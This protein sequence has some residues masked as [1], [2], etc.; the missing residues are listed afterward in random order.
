MQCSCNLTH[1]FLSDAIF[2]ELFGID[3]KENILLIPLMK[4]YKDF[5][6][7]FRWWF[8]KFKDFSK[9]LKTCIQMQRLS[10]KDFKA[11]RTLIQKG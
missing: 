11:I 2:E 5:L 4:N 3:L 10:I 6:K 7:D 9:I 1:K 8:V